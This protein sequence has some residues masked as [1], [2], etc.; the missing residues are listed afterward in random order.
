VV[1]QHGR[2]A[3][4]LRILAA[5]CA[6]FT[7]ML[8]V[9]VILGWHTGNA[10][11]I[12][13]HESYVP[14]QYN[15]ALGFALLGLGLF[16]V[17]LGNRRLILLSSAVLM[18][19]GI[20][21]LFQYIFDISLGIDQ[22][23]M[24]HYIRVETSHPGRMA[25]ITAL[26]FSISGT[27][28]FLGALIRGKH[29]AG[30]TIGVMTSFVVA[31]AFVAFVGYLSGLENAYGWGQMTGM[32]VH[33]SVGF[34]FGGAGLFA[35]AL[36]L[37][38]PISDA[39]W[40]S[41]SVG[42]GTL[43]AG[44]DLSQAMANNE[45]LR[46]SQV[47]DSRMS[48]VVSQLEHDLQ[49][50][51][52]A[53]ERIAARHSRLSNGERDQWSADVNQFADTTPGFQAIGWVDKNY[54]PL[55]LEPPA[56]DGVFS[57]SDFALG[58]VGRAALERVHETQQ[59]SSSGPIEFVQGDY[60]FIHAVPIF[61]N[62]AVQGSIIGVFRINELFDALTNSMR[63]DYEISILHRDMRLYGS[64]DHQAE[65]PYPLEALEGHFNIRIAPNEF[66]VRAYRSK[67]AIYV[68]LGTALLAVFISALVFFAQTAARNLRQVKVAHTALRG[69]EEYLHE[70]VDALPIGLL[71]LDI[72][73][74]IQSANQSLLNTLQYSHKEL[75]GHSIHTLIP[76]LL[77]VG[78]GKDL[79]DSPE[80]SIAKSM[81]DGHVMTALVKGG[82]QIPAQIGLAPV[83]LE[84]RLHVIVT[85]VDIS[86]RKDLE[87]DRENWRKLVRGIMKNAD[88]VMYVKAMDG[89]YLLVNSSFCAIFG[90]TEEEILDRTDRDLFPEEFATKFREADQKVADSGKAFRFEE[91]APLSDGVHHYISTKFPIHNEKGGIYAIAG[92]STDI[93][94]LKN[95]ER[96]LRQTEI[97]LAD[98]NRELEVRVEERTEELQMVNEELNQFSHIASHDL[99]EPLRKQMMFV[100]V[101]RDEVGEKLNPDAERAVRAIVSGA[102]RMQSL[103]KSLLAL[104][105]ARNRSVVMRTVRLSGIIDES[106]STLELSIKESGATVEV[107]ELPEIYG[108]EVLLIQ[109]FQNLISNAIRYAEKLHT[110][111]IKVYSSGENG[112]REI[113]VADNGIG[114]PQESLE[115][116]FAPFK[117]LHSRGEY[118]GTGIGL[119][120]C[121]KIVE[122]HGGSIRAESSVGNGSTFWMTF[123]ENKDGG[124][125][126]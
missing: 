43:A 55:W 114:I 63:N 60:G 18:L 25:P 44:I 46:V 56:G 4:A 2:G 115:S 84:E 45:D 38:E 20:L 112:N 100:N 121:R 49:D 40:I 35:V 23:L 54:R 98:L 82:G 10:L 119:S 93:T 30:R 79:M 64:K 81:G 8:G 110:P 11:L 113:A 66:L 58:G 75:V 29:A 120:I 77:Q 99:Q 104:S 83:K 72:E 88:E 90:L 78:F 37:S 1:E 57:G 74:N 92:V 126:D 28:L 14:M 96:S 24:E 69:N 15:T 70:V 103:V 85:V 27:A 95:K 50:R 9:V 59:P 106:L 124:E 117:R 26:C 17:L 41:I 107:E 51:F 108:D 42:I 52:V 53:L 122:R 62:G 31:L 91:V 21:T 111:C 6:L 16:F 34:L 118:P 123:P 105:R 67:L 65:S 3:V 32:A 97:E 89:R 73:G 109:L 36:A 94:E 5:C 86:R 68:L 19:V 71:S 47:M 33:T 61:E 13:V 101:L 116:I 7:A 87:A 48:G 76:D 39:R 22:L 125:N 102:E 12:Q 80:N